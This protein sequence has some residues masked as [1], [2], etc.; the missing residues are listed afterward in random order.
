MRVMPKRKTRKRGA[1]DEPDDPRL[2]KGEM[3]MLL[4]QLGIADDESIDLDN[5]TVSE[6]FCKDRYSS[7]AHEFRLQPGFACDLST[8]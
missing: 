4:F 1:E 8:G 5:L 6:L 2:D 7:R 3:G